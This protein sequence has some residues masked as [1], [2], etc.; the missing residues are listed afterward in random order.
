MLLDTPDTGAVFTV[1]DIATS[2]KVGSMSY[3]AHVPSSQRIEIGAVWVTPAFQGTHVMR[4]AVYLMLNYA[5]VSLGYRRVEWKC[6]SL[7]VRSRRAAARFGFQFEG[8][9]RQHMILK[10]ET[11]RD[12][13]WF[14]MTAGDWNGTEPGSSRPAVR[15]SF[16]ALLDETTRAFHTGSGFSE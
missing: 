13:A 10:G 8:L 7:N 1:V 15:A 11:S 4:E 14:A 6:H 9:F 5:F 3:L 12:S 2:A 16:L